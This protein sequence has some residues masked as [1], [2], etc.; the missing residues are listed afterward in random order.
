MADVFNPNE[1]IYGID[2][3]KFTVDDKEYPVSQVDMST[4]DNG[5]P[6][7]KLVIAAVKSVDSTTEAVT[8]DKLIE[9]QN[10]LQQKTGLTGTKTKLEFTISCPKDKQTIKLENWVL[11][12]AGIDPAGSGGMISAT[13]SLLHPIYNANKATLTLYNYDNSVRSPDPSKIKGND[14]ITSCFD[15]MKK[16]I[17]QKTPGKAKTRTATQAVNKN[18]IKNVEDALTVLEDNVVWYGETGS[19]FPFGTATMKKV[20]KWCLW[21]MIQLDGASPYRAYDSVA[22]SFM[23]TRSGTFLDDP[24]HVYPMSPW[25][26]S[27]GHIYDSEVSNISLPAVDTN[28]VSGVLVKYKGGKDT[29]FG[30][31]PPGYI[32]NVKGEGRTLVEGQNGAGIYLKYAT[33]LTGRILTPTLPMWISS[34]L[35]RGNPPKGPVI[36]SINNGSGEK[37]DTAAEKLFNTSM[38]RFG[39]MANKWAEDVFWHHYRAGVG[40][41][42][43]CR[44]MMTNPN[45]DTP[46]NFLRPGVCMTLRSSTTDDDLLQFYLYRVEH[47]LN[48]ASGQAYT[49]LVGQYVRPID[50]IKSDKTTVVS[51]D[52][53]KDGITNKTYS[54]NSAY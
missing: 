52:Q 15:A 53:V 3:F 4:M 35:K 6:G 44:F 26:K 37:Y 45:V 5:I 38:R 2:S 50:G 31:L 22:G 54:F 13:V 47:C 39:T 27:I 29:E 46:D 42:F 14:V 17:K 51:K 1:W 18:T 48:V 23:L 32:K 8:I 24:I 12:G 20:T 30:Y 28:P 43:N 40:V 10:E 21:S 7:I 41:A 16:Y 25:S 19:G 36:T 11:A 33:A 34:S 9:Y 49:R